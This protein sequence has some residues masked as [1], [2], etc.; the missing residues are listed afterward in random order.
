MAWLLPPGRF[1]A[2]SANT[3]RLLNLARMRNPKMPARPKLAR[4]S[5]CV[6]RSDG[7][8]LDCAEQR[9][10][11]AFEVQYIN[12]LTKHSFIEWISFACAAH[13][14]TTSKTSISICRATA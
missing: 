6:M 13:A 2:Y 8:I 12:R 10:G 1:D 4:N 7:G 9:L 5:R 11:N 3:G 14:H